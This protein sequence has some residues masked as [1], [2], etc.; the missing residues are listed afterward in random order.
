MIDHILFNCLQKMSSDI[1]YKTAKSIYDFTVKDTYGNDVSLEKYRGQV[2]VVVNTASQC[3]LT[4][5]NY[6]SLTKLKQQYEDKGMQ[7]N[8]VYYEKYIGY[9]LVTEHKEK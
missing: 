2:C 9:R 1:D 5:S 8:P 4:S 3:G 7:S 6:E